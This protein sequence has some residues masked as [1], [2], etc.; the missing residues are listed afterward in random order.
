M[1]TNG[2]R[3]EATSERYHVNV[4]RTF[5]KNLKPDMEISIG[6]NEK[7]TNR[8]LAWDRTKSQRPDT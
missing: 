5:Q 8:D 3:I 7:P 1:G 4:W 6:K 2:S